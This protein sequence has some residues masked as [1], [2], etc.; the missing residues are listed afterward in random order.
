[1]TG[2]K[3]DVQA[4]IKLDNYDPTIYKL[5]AILQNHYQKNKV[6]C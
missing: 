4:P 3:L 2:G 6:S 5:K 1:M